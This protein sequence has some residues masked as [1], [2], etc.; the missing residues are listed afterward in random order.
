MLGGKALLL[1]LKLAT[2]VQE[3]PALTVTVYA[4]G[5]RLLIFCVVAL[6]DHKNEYPGPCPGAGGV[7]VKDTAPLLATQDVLADGVPAMEKL[8][9]LAGTVTDVVLVQPLAP[10]TVT[11]YVPA[12]M[13]LRSSVVW[14]LLHVKE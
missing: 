13:P 3:P 5:A 14:L 8:M 12:V 7:S 10:L 11:V 9:L 1:T 2:F 6:F 4:P